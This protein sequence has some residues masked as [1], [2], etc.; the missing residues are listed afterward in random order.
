MKGIRGAS[1]VEFQKNLVVWKFVTRSP[2]SGI[3]KKVSEELSSMEIKLT[4][5]GKLGG[6]SCFRRT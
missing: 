5:K 1:L 4:K 3:S 6:Y 2:C